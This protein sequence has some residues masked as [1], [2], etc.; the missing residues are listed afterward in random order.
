MA[1]SS[2][3][4]SWTNACP[5]SITQNFKMFILYNVHLQNFQSYILKMYRSFVRRT[6][7]LLLQDKSV[8]GIKL[9]SM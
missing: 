9:L 3:K 6:A 1:K 5:I 8:G 2:R 4:D 7:K